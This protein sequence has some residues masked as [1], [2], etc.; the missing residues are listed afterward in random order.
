MPSREPLYRVRREQQRPHLRSHRRG[1]GRLLGTDVAPQAGRAERSPSD[2]T[3]QHRHPAPFRTGGH[4]APICQGAQAAGPYGGGSDARR[5]PGRGNRA[6]EFGRRPG[7]LRARGQNGSAP[8]TPRAGA[9]GATRPEPRPG[10]GPPGHRR[11]GRT[12]PPRQGPRPPPPHHDAALHRL[13]PRRGR[14]RRR[15]GRLPVGAGRA[16]AAPQRVHRPPA[17]PGTAGAS[18]T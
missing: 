16:R 6:F 9:G 15:R 13:H 5:G 11:G 8:G 14:R 7:V 4:G 2:G 17:G 3:L 12:R 10:T 18:C 1:L